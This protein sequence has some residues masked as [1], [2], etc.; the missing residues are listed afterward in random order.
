MDEED[1]Q[2]DGRAEASSPTGQPICLAAT[3]PS[4]GSAYCNPR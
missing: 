4:H 3:R 2:K 1:E